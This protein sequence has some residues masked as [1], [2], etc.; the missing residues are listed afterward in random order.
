MPQLLDI[1]IKWDIYKNTTKSPDE[2]LFLLYFLIGLVMDFFVKV[3]CNNK[4]NYSKEFS[5]F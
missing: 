4:D 2:G 5:I 1:L 3:F